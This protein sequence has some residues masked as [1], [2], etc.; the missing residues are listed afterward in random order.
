MGRGA[1]ISAGVS[2]V[3]SSAD[4][5]PGRQAPEIESLVDQAS[6]ASRSDCS[7]KGPCSQSSSEEAR[8]GSGP[9]VRAAGSWVQSSRASAS[10]AAGCSQAASPS[11][12]GGVCGVSWPFS[13]WWGGVA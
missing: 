7:S 8:E 12:A 2:T 9:A 4:S 11:A 6:S 5:L 13:S 10:G 3:F 1:V